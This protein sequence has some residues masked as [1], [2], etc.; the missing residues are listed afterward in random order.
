MNLT[1]SH[2]PRRSNRRSIKPT[3]KS[4]KSETASPSFKVG[5]VHVWLRGR[6]WDIRYH[7]RGRRIQ[8]R[9]GPDRKLASQLAAEI[10]AQLETGIPHLTSRNFSLP[11]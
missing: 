3:P 6:V 9:V 7:E 1:T 5:S 4:N 11:F 10:Y 8:R 2:S